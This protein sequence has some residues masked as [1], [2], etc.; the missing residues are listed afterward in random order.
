[1]IDLINVPSKNDGDQLS[2]QE[3]N[4]VVSGANSAISQLN[5]LSGSSI[6]KIIW[7]SGE[8]KPVIVADTIIGELEEGDTHYITTYTENENKIAIINNINKFYPTYNT[9]SNLD[10]TLE[11]Y[12][13]LPQNNKFVGIDYDGM[14]L[15]RLSSD[16]TLDDTFNNT[17]YLM[18][19]H[20]QILSDNSI[21]LCH[22]DEIGGYNILNKL[23]IDGN[24]DQTFKTITYSGNTQIS[25]G[26]VT[27]STD[28]VVA[29]LMDQTTYDSTVIRFNLDGT[30]DTTFNNYILTGNVTGYTSIY[31]NCI[32]TTSDDNIICAYEYFVEDY[33][34][35]IVK[36]N[37]DGTEDTNFKSNFTSIG[38]NV[39]RCF[40]SHEKLSNGS[41]FVSDRNNNIYKI[42]SDGTTDETFNSNIAQIID[43]YDNLYYFYIDSYVPL[44]IENDGLVLVTPTS[45][46]TSDILRIGA[47]GILISATHIDIG[48]CMYIF[49]S[50]QS[51]Y[52]VST[53]NDE[54]D[55]F[56]YSGL[57][58]YNSNFDRKFTTYIEKPHYAKQSQLENPIFSPNGYYLPT[59]S[60]YS[61]NLYVAYPD[62]LDHDFKVYLYSNDTETFNMIYSGIT[63]PNI[64]NDTIVL[65]ENGGDVGFEQL[66]DLNMNEI[67]GFEIYTQS[68]Y[69]APIF[70]D[71]LYCAALLSNGT[72]LAY[73]NNDLRQI[74]F[75]NSTTGDILISIT[76]PYNHVIFNPPVL[77]SAKLV[78]HI[79]GGVGLYKISETKIAFKVSYIIIGV[80]DIETETYT[81]EPFGQVFTLLKNISSNGTEYGAI[82]E[83]TESSLIAHITFPSGESVNIEQQQTE[84]NP[85]LPI[86]LESETENYLIRVSEDGLSIYDYN[87][88]DYTQMI[89]SSD[90]TQELL[91]AINNPLFV[92]SLT[93]FNFVKLGSEYHL[94]LNI[95]STD[96]RLQVGL[97]YK[98]TDLIIWEKVLGGIMRPNLNTTKINYYYEN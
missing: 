6:E 35:E 32:I 39:V 75:I 66:L 11:P 57:Y 53:V 50:N 63:P 49:K 3:F 5:T 54:Y 68:R 97:I 95:V 12:F 86:I 77:N 45:D 37:S 83:I 61:K 47:D 56:I 62:N 1:M 44:I 92:T 64:L 18:S 72:I 15:F 82:F 22:Y 21:I 26:F 71:M 16:L 85:D 59:I 43:T 14:R 98:S 93:N 74:D 34:Y 70:Q 7:L 76:E 94:I 89:F 10:L 65:F 9:Y 19:N 38:I 73:A 87:N 88:Y 33:I 41:F 84:G 25:G 51:T 78:N 91:Q 29:I 40:Y 79:S 96:P 90:D 60:T 48:S 2:A 17:N 67:S 55:D 30:E 28:K 20:I 31:P 42:N 81:P 80:Y 46:T 4:L 27:Q 23:D 69:Y 24:I 36:L 52:A 13:L 8:T 58:L